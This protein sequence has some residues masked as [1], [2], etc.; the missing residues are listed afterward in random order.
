MT[1]TIVAS[2][3]LVLFFVLASSIKTLAWHQK[4]FETQLTFFKS[5]GLNRQI[6]FL[7]GVL[8]FSGAVM[9]VLGL[10]GWAPMLF[11]MIGATLLAFVSVGALYFHVR[12]DTWQAGVPAMITL[13]LSSYV[14]SPILGLL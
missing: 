8:E 14:A 2:W 10:L 5:Y 6:M 11:S 9:L 12:F 1:I 13:L 3:V 4:V 7:V